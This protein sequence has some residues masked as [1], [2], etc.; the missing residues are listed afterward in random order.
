MKL[1]FA[2]NSIF[3][4]LSLQL[5]A[6]KGEG[7]ERIFI[8]KD[9][10][11]ND[12]SELEILIDMLVPG[13]IVIVYNLVTFGCLTDEL[14]IVLNE[15]QKKQVEFISIKDGLDTTTPFGVVFYKLIK[16]LAEACFHSNDI[17]PPEKGIKRRGRP[18]CID[19]E[20]FKKLERAKKLYNRGKISVHEIC[21][22]LNISRATFFRYL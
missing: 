9:Y 8:E 16:V 12:E 7:C 6:L 3:F 21:K 5:E 14:A 10:S 19:Q 17:I 20:K 22:N 15:F 18:K 13:D 2:R 11:I 4:E 1:G